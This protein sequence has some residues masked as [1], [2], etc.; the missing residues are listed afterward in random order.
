[1]ESWSKNI[2]GGSDDASPVSEV[3]HGRNMLVHIDMENRKCSKPE[4]AAMSAGLNTAAAAL[5]L[6]SGGQRD[7]LRQYRVEKGAG[8]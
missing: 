7:A 5:T 3:V 6:A 2:C 1:V 4:A 8:E